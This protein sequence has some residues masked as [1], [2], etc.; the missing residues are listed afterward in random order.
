MSWK[1]G[2]FSE[3][4]NLEEGHIWGSLEFLSSAWAT[5]NKSHFE[6]S[7]G[8][9]QLGAG[10]LRSVIEWKLRA[11]VCMGKEKAWAQALIASDFKEVDAGW[12]KM[13]LQR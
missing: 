13:Q 2:A 9:C 7:K 4:W 11:W 12:R 3:T 10:A 8:I 5:L 1:K 6:L